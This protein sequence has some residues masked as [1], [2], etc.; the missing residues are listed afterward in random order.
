M[1]ETIDNAKN[2]VQP[3]GI[4]DQFA[5]IATLYEQLPDARKRGLRAR[6][7]AQELGISEAQWVAASCGPIRSVRLKGNGQSLLPAIEL[8]GPVMALTRNNGCVHER[9]GTYQN[10]QANGSIGLA[11]G[12]DIDLR[13][14]FNHWQDVFA[15]EEAGRK[16]LQFFDKEGVAIHKIYCTDAT[17][18]KAYAELVQGQTDQPNWPDIKPIVK[19]SAKDSIDDATEFRRAWLAMTDTHDFFGLLKKFNVSRLG[20]LRA[21]GHDLAQRIGL[22]VIQTVLQHVANT[23]LSIMCFVGNRGAIQI[24]SGPINHIAMRGSWLNV[25][26]PL[27][28][29]HLDI[30]QVA[31]VWVV[32]KPTNDGWVTSLEVFDANGDLIVQFFGARKPGTAEL[33]DWRQEMIALCHYPLKD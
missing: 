19:D 31:E 12:A 28:N 16:S 26:D 18:M 21:A 6:A 13:F 22:D 23:D 27:F 29:L 2:S 1:F 9:H 15:V 5:G 3:Y 20:A 17:D 7:V 33:P 24:H 4:D 30:D 11:L 8:L 32:N 25:L 14:F 10:V